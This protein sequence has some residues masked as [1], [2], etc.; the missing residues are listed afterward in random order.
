MIRKNSLMQSDGGYITPHRSPQRGDRTAHKHSEMK[1]STELKETRQI[2]TNSQHQWTQPTDLDQ[3]DF[4]N[5]LQFPQSQTNKP[6]NSD[7]FNKYECMKDMKNIYTDIHEKIDEIQAIFTSETQKHKRALLKQFKEKLHEIA[8]QKQPEGDVEVEVE[9]AY[10]IKKYKAIKKIQ[11]LHIWRQNDCTHSMK[12]SHQNQKGKPKTLKRQMKN[13]HHQ[14]S[15]LMILA[16]KT[17]N[18]SKVSNNNNRIA[19]NQTIHS[20]QSEKNISPSSHQNDSYSVPS[21]QQR[22]IQRHIQLMQNGQ[23]Q[24]NNQRS[25]SEQLQYY[26]KELAKQRSRFT[27][28]RQ[29]HVDSDSER[30]SLME[31]MR[32]CVNDIH[33][34]SEDNRVG[35]NDTK[36]SSSGSQSLL[37]LE[38]RQHDS[39]ESGDTYEK[40][41][42]GN[43]KERRRSQIGI[44]T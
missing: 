22:T 11:H 18:Y 27:A 6:I 43:I 26:Q 38:S 21:R 16:W 25:L 13:A 23:Q 10:W 12:Q 3:N 39:N 17:V 7:K 40:K 14:R 37:K 1:F 34:E 28:I 29:Q 2:L 4:K 5:E 32:L 36:L 30:R 8:C 9:A 15:N 33:F 24:Q 35:Q 42:R 41:E 19:L 31:L 20:N 44:T